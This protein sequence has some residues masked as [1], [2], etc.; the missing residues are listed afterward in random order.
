LHFF[1]GF[2]ETKTQIPQAVFSSLRFA[3]LTALYWPCIHFQVVSW[4]TV[5]ISLQSGLNSQTCDE[6]QKPESIHSLP[7]K[8]AKAGANLGQSMFSERQSARDDDK[9]IQP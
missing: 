2:L 8:A 4:V 9:N 1:Q 6:H 7:E 3:N 5:I